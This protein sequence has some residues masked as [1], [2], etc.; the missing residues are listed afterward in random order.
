MHKLDHS[1]AAHEGTGAPQRSSETMDVMIVDPQEQRSR[2]LIDDLKSLLEFRHS[3]KPTGRAALESFSRARFDTIVCRPDLGDLDCWRFIRMIRS[4]RFGF[5]ATPVVVLC[6]KVELDELAPMI[7][8]H[9]MLVLEDDSY[10]LT[11]TLVSM[12]EGAGRASVLVVEDEVAAAKSAKNALDKYYRVDV[13]YEGRSALQMWREKHHSVVLLDLMLPG[14]SGEEVLAAITEENPLQVV[15]VL[16]AHD[17]PETHEALI[18]AGATDFVSKPLP[19]HELP[20]L[21]ARALREQSCLRNVDR[22]RAEAGQANEVA[23]RIRAANY[24]FVRGQ[25]GRGSAHLSRALFE[26]RSQKLSD[27]Q[28]TQLLGDFEST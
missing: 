2:H 11:S 27:D 15:I 6:D 26:T 7:D 16:T 1:S 25:S 19:M 24:H 23:A 18:M 28:W 14:I 12:K 21:C 3:I 22:A 17:A 10:G 8:E 5:G 9:T 4:G 20:E 13:A